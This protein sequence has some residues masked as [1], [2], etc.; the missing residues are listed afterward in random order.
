MARFP[1]DSIDLAAEIEGAANAL[2]SIAASIRNEPD[3]RL[4]ALT[5][6]LHASIVFDDIQRVLANSLRP[7][8]VPA[9]EAGPV[10]SSLTQ[11][12]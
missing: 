12:G 11:I 6:R 5:A 7:T 8:V 9:F 1:N 3:L 2:M 4:A 10:S